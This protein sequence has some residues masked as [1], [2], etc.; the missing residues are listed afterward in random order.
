MLPRQ[1]LSESDF[2]RS[3]SSIK[4]TFWHCED[5]GDRMTGAQL[6][7]R[8]NATKLEFAMEIAG[9]ARMLYA[10]SVPGL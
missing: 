10:F 8:G 5:A 9:P 6:G 1:V 2:D 4:S 3:T 7:F